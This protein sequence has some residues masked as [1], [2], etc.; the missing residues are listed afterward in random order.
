MRSSSRRSRGVV[1]ALVVFALLAACQSGT[2]KPAQTFAECYESSKAVLVG[3]RRALFGASEIMGAA[4][5]GEGVGGDRKLVVDDAG[6]Y[7]GIAKILWLFS[8]PAES[9]VS[10]SATVDDEEVK[11][12]IG[13]K[14]RSRF[15]TTTQVGMIDPD[16]SEVPSLVVVP[17]SGCVTIS[18]TVD[19][20]SYKKLA[21]VWVSRR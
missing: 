5:L 20:E 12:D 16:W 3:D 7:A 18:G 11:W 14:R 17:Q 19:G 1:V 13:G 15:E 2:S 8:V 9:P 4:L 21:S 6:A 10:L